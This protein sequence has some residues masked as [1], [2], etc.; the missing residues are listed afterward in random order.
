MGLEENLVELD[1]AQKTIIEWTQEL[2]SLHGIYK[3][4]PSISFAQIRKLNTQTYYMIEFMKVLSK[5]AMAGTTPSTL[6]EIL[7]K[8]D[9]AVAKILAGK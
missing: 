9:P 6:S 3:T 8:L 7:D 4:N 1:K 2:E 5:Q